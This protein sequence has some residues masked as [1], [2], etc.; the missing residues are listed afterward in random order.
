MADKIYRYWIAVP[1][2][3]EAVALDELREHVPEI[4]QVAVEP[5]GRVGQIFFTYKRSPGRL[6]QL[7]SAIQCAGLIVQMHGV[8]VG[9]PGLEYIC[10]RIARCDLTPGKSL[11]QAQSTAIDTHAFALSATLR[12]R[13]R[14]SAAELT[15]AVAAVL[16][17]QH[18]LRPGKGP[19]LLRLHLQLTGRRALLGLRLGA[20]AVPNE[21]MI[22][23]LARLVAMQPG[24]CVLWARRDPGELAALREAFAPR[25]LVSI[26]ACL[27]AALDYLPLVGARLDYAFSLAGENPTAELAELARGVACR[28]NRRGPSRR[29]RSL[30]RPFGSR[31]LSFGSLGRFGYARARASVSAGRARTFGRGRGWAFTG[32]AVELLNWGGLVFRS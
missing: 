14:F 26:R 20:G 30:H 18:G 31:G 7:R 21:A 4:Q 8:T 17:D 5:G 2:G 3:L 29:F 1:S 13:Y 15:E 16:R 22:Y 23:C 32:G 27:I 9:R 25:L 19:H 12:G 11:A 28:W 6:L 24:A 10:K